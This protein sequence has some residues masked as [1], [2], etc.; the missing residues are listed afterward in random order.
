MI[1]EV[2]VVVELVDGEE[3]RGGEPA[4]NFAGGIHVTT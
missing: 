1:Q 4:I 3:R 2:E